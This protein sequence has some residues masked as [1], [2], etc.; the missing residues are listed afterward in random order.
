MSATPFSSFT[1]SLLLFIP[2]VWSLFGHGENAENIKEFNNHNNERFR[3][4]SQSAHSQHHNLFA[5]IGRASG[6]YNDGEAATKHGKNWEGSDEVE[7]GV[8]VGVKDLLVSS[9]NASHA[10]KR[11]Q[12][13]LGRPTEASRDAPSEVWK[14]CSPPHR[15]T[16]SFSLH[17]SNHSMSY[18]HRHS[19]DDKHHQRP[20]GT[21][22]F[23]AVLHQ[24]LFPT[25]LQLNKTNATISSSEKNQNLSKKIVKKYIQREFFHQKPK[26]DFFAEQKRRFSQAGRTVEKH[27]SGR[28]LQ[29]SANYFDENRFEKVALMRDEKLKINRK[30]KSENVGKRKN[31]ARQLEQAQKFFLKRHQLQRRKKKRFAQNRKFQFKNSKKKHKSEQKRQK[32][33][34]KSV[35]H[36]AKL[37]PTTC[38]RA[39]SE[40]YRNN[41]DRREEP[42]EIQQKIHSRHQKNQSYHHHK[43]EFFHNRNNI[44][45]RKNKA[46]EVRER[47]SVWKVGKKH[48]K[49]LEKKHQVEAIFSATFHCPVISSFFQTAEENN[50]ESYKGSHNYSA[51]FATTND[52]PSALHSHHNTCRC[53]K[54]NNIECTNI[55]SIPPF[56]HSTHVFNAF[57]ANNQNITS[58]PQ[59]SFKHLKVRKLLLDFNNLGSLLS[60]AALNGLGGHLEELHMGACG[61]KT[62]PSHMIENLGK[63]TK[64]HIWANKL[65]QIPGKFFKKSRTLHEVVAWGN[66][67][68]KLD[69]DSFAG[70]WKLQKLDLDRNRIEQVDKE[71]FRHLGSLQVCGG[72]W[73]TVA[74]DSVWWCM[75][76]CGCVW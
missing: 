49:I 58:L 16:T 31:K 44:I 3:L 69:R 50:F 61:L 13:S 25:K 19:S 43:S 66:Q 51:V 38:N 36:T 26:K 23:H 76:A 7:G 17:P 56:R 48:E 65:Q 22:N 45:K 72:L 11:A 46:R 37:L 59:N 73:C 57:V 71:V 27:L 6:G 9:E 40:L 70:L 24:R 53:T 64:F 35:E 5:D 15:N 52:T 2:V 8:L 60:A 32:K 21:H 10:I 62:L 39:S 63:L 55:F 30:T 47:K 14:G 34:E 33:K 74:C 1:A 54:K 28:S 12:G 67:I 18:H 4:F 20:S 29:I 68:D 42:E 75:L 41:T